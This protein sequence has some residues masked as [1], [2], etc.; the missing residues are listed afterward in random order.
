MDIPPGMYEYTGAARKIT[1]DSLNSASIKLA[2]KGLWLGYLK[3]FVD[4]LSILA[5]T[6]NANLK[7]LGQFGDNS[8][9]TESNQSLQRSMLNNKFSFKINYIE[10]IDNELNVVMS[11]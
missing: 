8:N 9:D 10:I 11:Y 3:S 4:N 2:H 1:T 7:S 5:S 6:K